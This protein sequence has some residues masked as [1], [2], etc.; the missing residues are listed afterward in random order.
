[1]FLKLLASEVLKHPDRDNEVVEA[2][3]TFDAISDATTV[4]NLETMTY[5]VTRR[6]ACTNE[7]RT[8]ISLRELESDLI[9]ARRLLIQQDSLEDD[10]V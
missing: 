3:K 4:E 9:K 2:M 6:Y 8:S 1:M 10:F 7:E 5:L